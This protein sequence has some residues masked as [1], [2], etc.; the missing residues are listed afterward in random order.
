MEVRLLLLFKEPCVAQSTFDFPMQDPKQIQ[1]S[2]RFRN[3]VDR[4]K[5][6]EAVK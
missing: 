6:K 5:V 3:Y 2:D 4:K 1:L